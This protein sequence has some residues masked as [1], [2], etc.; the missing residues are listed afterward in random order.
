[1]R[2]TYRYSKIYSGL[3]PEFIEGDVFKVIIPFATQNISDQATI[4]GTIQATNQADEKI[5]D[6]L[7]F[8]KVPRSRN[9]IQEFMNLSDR[10]HFRKT[11]L[12]PLIKGGLLKP[13]IPD[14][15]TSPNQKYYSE[16]R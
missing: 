3:E 11:I 13:T 9:E 4:Q 8:C 12:N 14:K 6:L 15:P 16:K 1:M 10:G 7:E 5:K 2:N